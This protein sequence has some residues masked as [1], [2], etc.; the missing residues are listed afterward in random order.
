MRGKIGGFSK[1][2]RLRMI[3]RLASV[4][5]E[6]LEHALWLDLTYPDVMTDSIRAARD[7][8][9]LEKRLRRAFPSARGIWKKELQERGAIHFHLM[10]F[11]VDFIPHGWLAENWYQ[12]VGSGNPDHLKAGT[13][14]SRVHNRRQAAGYA[15]KYQAKEEKSESAESVGGRWWGMFG[16]WEQDLGEIIEWVVNEVGISRVWR[17]LDN[18][19]LASAR[20]VKDLEKRSAKI[21]A[22]RRARRFRHP[23]VVG[24][25]FLGDVGALLSNVGRLIASA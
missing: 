1:Q 13:S 3:K 9:V 2:A 21:E 22:A 10:V 14:I 4:R 7:L 24:S 15:C 8:H 20:R 19:R 6:V 18:W 25:F 17:V 23:L 16:D 5:D 11:G 12:V